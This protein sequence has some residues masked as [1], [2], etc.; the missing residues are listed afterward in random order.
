[1]RDDR[2]LHGPSKK[3]RRVARSSTGAQIGA[4]RGCALSAARRVRG[5]R[6][7]SAAEKLAEFKTSDPPSHEMLPIGNG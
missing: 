7:R 4:R 6:C 5:P 2:L 3:C 1:M